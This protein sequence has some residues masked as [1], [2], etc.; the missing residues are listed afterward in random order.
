MS[1]EIYLNTK[2]SLK[3]Q[4]GK[5]YFTLQSLKSRLSHRELKCVETIIASDFLSQIAKS[6]FDR[7][8]KSSKSTNLNSEIDT[9]RFTQCGWKHWYII[10][11]QI[12]WKLHLTNKTPLTCLVD[13]IQIFWHQK[14]QNYHSNLSDK[15]LILYTLQ[16]Y[17]RLLWL[18][19]ASL[20]VF[21]RFLPVPKQK[22]SIFYVKSIKFSYTNNWWWFKLKINR[23][24]A[25][26]GNSI[27]LEPPIS[28]TNC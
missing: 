19:N 28:V 13:E 23:D 6:M 21:Y 27:K 22:L 12:V 3:N 24:F 7:V 5:S 10:H 4:A 11:F 2:N 1:Y 25:N 17:Q 15:N 26:T 18:L 16:L 9:T 20:S 14:L 8:V